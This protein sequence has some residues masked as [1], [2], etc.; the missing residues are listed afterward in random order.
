M[1]VILPMQRRSNSQSSRF[2]SL[3]ARL[4]RALP[5]C[6]TEAD[7]VQLLYSELHPVFGY[8]PIN[9]QVLEREG[10]YQHLAIDHGLLQDVGRRRLSES[11][12][13]PNYQRAE[14]VVG[15]PKPKHLVPI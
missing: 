13:G 10:W 1:M 5:S 8:D 15:Y 7:I 9:L 4:V 11:I 2:G 6:G 12:F 3:K 14:T